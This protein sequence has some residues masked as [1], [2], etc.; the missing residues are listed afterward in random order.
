MRYRPILPATAV[1]MLLALVALAADVNGTWK[2]DFTSPDGTPRTNT[3]TLKADGQKLT[4]TVKGSED[5]T[6][7]EN[8]KINGDVLSFTAERPFGKFSYTGKISGN[9]IKLKVE[10][11]DQSFD[12]TAKRVSN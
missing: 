11:N 2:A 4:G 10:F 12:I 9:E 7:I 3:F 8:G 1:A 6:Q 5:E